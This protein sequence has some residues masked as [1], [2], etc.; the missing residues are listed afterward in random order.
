VEIVY[1]TPFNYSR[2]D[3]LEAT[4]IKRY[5][6]KFY[7]RPSDMVF[8]GF[9]TTFHFGK[10]LMQHRG[11]LINNLSNSQYKLFND[12]D[13]VP[14]KLRTANVLPDYLENK[15]LYFIRKQGGNL[16]TII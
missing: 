7:S 3:N 11:D 15:K 13:I 4:L 6:S 14:V 8:R 12:F 10:L 16:K 1:S 2:S 5:R 9:E